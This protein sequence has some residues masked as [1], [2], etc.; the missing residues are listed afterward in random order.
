MNECE[1]K[2]WLHTMALIERAASAP[3]TSPQGKAK[4]EDD[5]NQSINLS[6]HHSFLLTLSRYPE[7]PANGATVI[8]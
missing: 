7:S 2:E 8:K 1:Y 5:C 4:N 6:F 3:L